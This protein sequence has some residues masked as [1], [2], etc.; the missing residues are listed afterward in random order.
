MDGRLIVCVRSRATMRS[1]QTLWLL[2]AIGLFKSVHADLHATASEVQVGSSIDAFDNEKKVE[3][4]SDEV[5]DDVNGLS[6]S[7]TSCAPPPQTSGNDT[8]IND[9]DAQVR[10]IGTHEW[11]IGSNGGCSDSFS[12][13]YHD[14]GG[15]KALKG[16]VIVE[17]HPQ[18]AQ[19]GC[20]QLH[21]WH[22]GGPSSSRDC[23]KFQPFRAPVDV[24]D[25]SGTTY[26][27]Y[28]N[29]SVDG[30]QWNRVAC[31]ELA[32]GKQ[33]IVASNEGTNSCPGGG[34]ASSGCYWVADAFM[35]SYLATACAEVPSCS[36][37][38]RGEVRS[39]PAGGGWSAAT[40]GDTSADD[41]ALSPEEARSQIQ[42]WRF[43]FFGCLIALIVALMLWM[44]SAITAY[45]ARKQQH[46]QTQASGMRVIYLRPDAWPMHVSNPGGDDALTVPVA[47]V[48]IMPPTEIPPKF[49]ELPSPYATS[50]SS[51]SRFS[52]PDSHHSPIRPSPAGG[53]GSPRPPS[54]GIELQSSPSSTPG[55]R[56]TPAR[57]FQDRSPG[58]SPARIAIDPRV[59]TVAAAPTDV[60]A[61]EG[62]GAGSTPA[63]PMRTRPASVVE[64][65]PMP[66]TSRNRLGEPQP[67]IGPLSS[68]FYALERILSSR[69]D[70][71]D[72]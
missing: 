11:S 26:R 57:E 3:E 66:N 4:P 42:A 23:A 7:S 65:L 38:S 63:M 9:F 49:V 56:S 68:A 5:N 16:S 17:F 19:C 72:G 8:V 13:D 45:S 40:P 69:S 28:V 41:E 48:E 52:T 10:S 24:V 46:L 61:R 36:I 29:Q 21:E 34:S 6:G 31:Y 20:Y 18:L 27:A 64:A 71:S 37:Q 25:G 1:R 53:H 50:R 35:L 54:P 60:N 30:G 2:M 55:L 33:R 22:P 70:D 43:G 14:D 32:S 47:P 62:L 12:G 51:S 59:P 67:I 15:N 58:S 39:Q 44:S